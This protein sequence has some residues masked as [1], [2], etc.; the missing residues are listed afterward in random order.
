MPP[1]NEKTFLS[2][3][4]ILNHLFKKFWLLVFLRNKVWNQT[5]TSQFGLSVLCQ[6]LDNFL[7]VLSSQ[8][9]EHSLQVLQ[10][11]HRHPTDSHFQ[12]ML[13]AW[14]FVQ[15]SFLVFVHLLQQIEDHFVFDDFYKKWKLV[16]SGPHDVLELHH[17]HVC[18]TKEFSQTAAYPD[19]PGS[20]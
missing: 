20:G 16:M 18:C 4:W 11:R 15:Q 7:E 9:E 19:S 3:F 8:M 6:T 12:W 2:S 1:E 14:Y 5:K 17:I 10:N 13:L